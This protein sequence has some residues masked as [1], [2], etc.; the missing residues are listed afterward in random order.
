MR[1]G[2]KQPYRWDK[3]AAWYRF[4][5]N[6]KVTDDKFAKHVAKATACIIANEAQDFAIGK[7]GQIGAKASR[8]VPRVAG[9]QFGQGQ[10][11]Y[12][13]RGVGGQIPAA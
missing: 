11:R 4:A 3:A 1:K 7:F 6:P 13:Q 10:L 12:W 5:S 9:L 8:N 2:E